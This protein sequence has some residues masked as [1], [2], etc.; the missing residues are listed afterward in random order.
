M[1]FRA[2]G[3]VVVRIVVRAAVRAAAAR[4]AA[5]GLAKGIRRGVGN[6]TS[7]Q[8]QSVRN[9]AAAAAKSLL[10]ARTSG[11][12]DELAEYS[13]ELQEEAYAIIISAWF[14][15]IDTMFMMTANAGQ[16]TVFENYVIPYFSFALEQVDPKDPEW[17]DVDIGEYMYFMG[18]IVETGNQIMNE[19]CQ[20]AEDMA[21]EIDD[22]D[23]AI[24]EVLLEEG[25]KEDEFF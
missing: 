15:A 23:D 2:I 16:E 12:I 7:A 5:R 18:E 10:A 22:I 25:I 9:T 1:R 21:S 13:E 20:E 3:R 14:D 19:A 17:P 11:L 4:M 6:K 8:R 24:E